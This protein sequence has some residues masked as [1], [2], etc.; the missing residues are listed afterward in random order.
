MVGKIGYIHNTAAVTVFCIARRIQ[1]GPLEAST[2]NI[3]AWRSGDRV[4]CLS[5]KLG[6][7]A[8]RECQVRQWSSSTF[9]GA[10]SQRAGRSIK[11]G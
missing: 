4:S 1:R 11:K 2:A 10:P 6:Q 3:G 7:K 9:R 5:R 8:P